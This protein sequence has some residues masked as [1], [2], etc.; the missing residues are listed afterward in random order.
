MH[1]HSFACEFEIKGTESC[2]EGLEQGHGEGSI[3]VEVVLANSPK[4]HVNPIIIIL[5][6]QLEVLHRSLINP[7]VEIQDESLD[8]YKKVSYNC[9]KLTYIH[10]T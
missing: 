4:L 1:L 2:T 8:L 10:S 6:Y 9:Y 3:H 5:V 7:T